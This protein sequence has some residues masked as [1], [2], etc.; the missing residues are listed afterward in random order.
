MLENRD[1]DSGDIAYAFDDE[2][3]LNRVKKYQSL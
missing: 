2:A 3:F 1:Y